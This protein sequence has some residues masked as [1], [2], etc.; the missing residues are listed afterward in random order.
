MPFIN[1]FCVSICHRREGFTFSKRKK[2][3]IT[4]C[5]AVLLLLL[6]KAW[7]CMIRHPLALVDPRL[8]SLEERTSLEILLVLAVSFWY[9]ARDHGTKVPRPRYVT[10]TFA[11]LQMITFVNIQREILVGHFGVCMIASTI[12]IKRE[13]F[14]FLS[15]PRHNFIQNHSQ[16]TSVS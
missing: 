16:T 7:H 8:H 15:S 1:E 11:L 9:N 3:V 13:G 12:S 4:F 6:S 2:K 10:V 14:S 5:T